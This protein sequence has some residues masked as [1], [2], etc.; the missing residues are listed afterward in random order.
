MKAKLIAPC[1]MNCGICKA[2]LRD[3]NKC[4]GCREDDK[5]K[6]VSCIRCTIKNCEE[7]KKSKT[8]FCFECEKFPCRRLKQLDK[9]YVGKYRMSM[10]DNLLLIKKNGVRKLLQR[11]NKKWTCK[12]GETVSC[13]DL[14]C[15]GCGAKVIK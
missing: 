7:I 13:H 12:C 1:G 5:G 15:F 2:Y 10:I 11:E 9:R 6:P 3:K 4:I 14:T 8:G